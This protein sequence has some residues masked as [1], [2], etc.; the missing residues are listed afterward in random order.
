[1][2]P[3]LK[4]TLIALP[5]LVGGFIVYKRLRKPPEEKPVNPIP[6]GGGGGGSQKPPSPPKKGDEFPLSKGSKGPFVKRLQNA[7]LQCDPK[8]LPKFGADGGFGSETEAAL[9]KN[10]Y[11]TTVDLALLQKI[12]AECNKKYTDRLNLTVRTTSGTTPVDYTK[13]SNVYF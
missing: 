4:W 5:L 3:W 9:K 12:E 6:N 2:K 10:G 1:M 7:L 11:A 8:A 13:Q